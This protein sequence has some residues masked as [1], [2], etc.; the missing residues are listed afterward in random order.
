VLVETM[1]TMAEKLGITCLAEGIET[2]DQLRFLRD[3][4][5]ALGQGF[6]YSRPVEVAAFNRLLGRPRRSGQRAA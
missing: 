2:D 6:L 4:G 3:N 5:C 1:I